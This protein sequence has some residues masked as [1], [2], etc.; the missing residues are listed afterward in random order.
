ML[1]KSKLLDQLLGRQ[2]TVHAENVVNLFDQGT[3]KAKQQCE[4]EVSI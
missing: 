3:G 4:S 2:E 1:I